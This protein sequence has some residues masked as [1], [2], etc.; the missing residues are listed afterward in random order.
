MPNYQEDTYQY[1][2]NDPYAVDVNKVIKEN[3]AA[4]ANKVNWLRLPEGEARSVWRIL[5]WIQQ[6][7]FFKKVVKHF[8]IPGVNGAL[9]CPRS[10]I[11]PETNDKYDCAIDETRWVFEKSKDA[12]EVAAAKLMRGSVQYYVNAV[13]MEHPQLGVGVL[14][15]PHSIWKVLFDWLTTPGYQLFYHPFHGR[16]IIIKSTLSAAV[17]PGTNTKAREYTVTPD[18]KETAIEDE[19]WLNHLYDLETIVGIPTYEFTK[20]CIQRLITGDPTYGQEEVKTNR[21]VKRLAGD[22]DFNFNSDETPP[23]TLNG[24]VKTTPSIQTPAV[25]NI[26]PVSELTSVAPV[27]ASAPTSKK[28]VVLVPTT[29]KGIDGHRVCF[30]KVFDENNKVCLKCEEIDECEIL[31]LKAARANKKTVTNDDV[32]SQMAELLN[33]K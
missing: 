16:N 3:T 32:A 25:Q 11:N 33:K 7:S 10:F 29:E 8:N 9:T 31:M 24:Q 15:L 26:G 20:V 1:D 19:D 2:P 5:P 12:S 23:S 22:T 30:T 13:D 14:G 21:Y 4:T 28:E 17:V 18:A 27:F 6:R